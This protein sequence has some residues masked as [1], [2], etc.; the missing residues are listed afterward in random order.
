MAGQLSVGLPD[1]V[2][3]HVQHGKMTS[4]SWVFAG[5][6][7]LSWRYRCVAEAEQGSCSVRRSNTL[8]SIHGS[9][10]QCV[11]L[12][13][14]YTCKTE[15]LLYTLVLHRQL[16]LSQLWYL[17]WTNIVI[18]SKQINDW[19]RLCELEH[20]LWMLVI[21]G[22][23]G[24]PIGANAYSLYISLFFCWYNWVWCLF[25]AITKWYCNGLRDG[26][27]GATGMGTAG[28]TKSWL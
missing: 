23:G 28:A 27:R 8:A 11:L 1:S 3:R 25:Y 10:D 4:D 14:A 5:P 24:W 7:M 19:C 18:P 21:D 9:S 22:Y 16:A 6:C 13:S 17:Y 26:S 12:S 15:D 20:L 2:K